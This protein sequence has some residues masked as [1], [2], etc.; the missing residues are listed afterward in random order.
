V[1]PKKG[2]KSEK[3]AGET[4]KVAEAAGKEKE[5]VAAKKAIA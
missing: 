5:A 4:S 2:V 1:A 3:E